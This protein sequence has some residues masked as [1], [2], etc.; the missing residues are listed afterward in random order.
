MCVIVDGCSGAKGFFSYEV[1]GGV[2]S[3]DEVSEGEDQNR[4]DKGNDVWGVCRHK[5]SR[6]LLQQRCVKQPLSV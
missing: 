6:G 4:D 2:D 5:R 1:E 3:D